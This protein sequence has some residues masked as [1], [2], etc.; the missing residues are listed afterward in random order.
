MKNEE[1]F[2]KILEMVVRMKYISEEEKIKVK[3][4]DN[5]RDTLNLRGL[6]LYEFWLE[7]EVVFNVSISDEEIAGEENIKTFEELIVLL[8][9]KI[10]N[11]N[12]LDVSFHADEKGK[13]NSFYDKMSNDEKDLFWDIQK[14]AKESLSNPDIERSNEVDYFV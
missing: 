1:I 13:K 8:D 3:P 9:K 11:E 10:N 5:I 7:L 14:T 12:E 2:E 6:D 4:E